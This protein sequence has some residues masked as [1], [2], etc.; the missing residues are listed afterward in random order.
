MIQD[1]IDKSC[2]LDL[3]SGSGNLG[4][5]SLSNGASKVYF[6]DKN[7]KCIEI[8]NNNLKNFDL[9]QNSIVANMN[10]LDALNYYKKSNICFDLV[11]LDPPYKEHI[12]SE[13]ILFLLNNNLLN[14][15]SL[16][17]CEVNNKE[18]FINDKVKLFKERNYG[19]KSIIIYKYE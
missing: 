5:E 3:F 8:I 1:Y 6:N 17:I 11:F 10:Y 9:L 16:I 19:D 7:K 18:I 14:K 15:N 4:I 12:I 13:I 2:V